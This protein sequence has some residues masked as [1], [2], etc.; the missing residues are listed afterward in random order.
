MKMSKKIQTAGAPT[1]SVARNCGKL[2]E[3]AVWN[4]RLSLGQTMQGGELR[5]MEWAAPKAAPPFLV[6]EENPPQE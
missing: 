3:S 2:P 1:R 4:L 6:T 5:K